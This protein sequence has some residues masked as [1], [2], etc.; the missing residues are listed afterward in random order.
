MITSAGELG[1]LCRRLA[2]APRIAFD[3][4]FVSEDTYRPEL[5]LI[6][7]AAG[8]GL[9]VI[10]ALAVGDVRPFWEVVAAEGHETIVHAGRQ[11]LLFCLESVGRPPAGLVDVQVAAALIGLE[12]PAGYG[13]LLSRLLGVAP[14]KGETRTDWR[15]RPLSERQ[16]H[17][18]LEDVRHLEPLRDHIF[19]RLDKL[20]RRGWFADEMAAWTV[21]IESS[22][23]RERWR[24]VSGSA[25]LSPRSQAIVRALWQWREQEA[26][27]RNCPTRQVLRDD[28]IV[29]LAKRRSADPK[30]ILAI[31]GMERGDLRRAAPEMSR[32][33]A[34]ALELPDRECP[35]SV[36][37]D[38]NP[39]LNLLG[40]FLSAALT[41][42]CRGAEVAHSLVGTAHDIRELAAFHLNKPRENPHEPPLLARG[43]RAQLVGNL[44]EELLSGRLAI[45]IQN[46][47][48][49]HPLVFEPS[50]GR[51]K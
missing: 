43:W 49:E 26:E 20:D 14:Q 22:R 33:I 25:S 11:E 37:T 42:V 46:P 4:E 27:R 16:I 50:A 24:R 6:Q 21:D 28:L 13:T 12:Y 1:E 7:V 32:A 44:F 17:Y 39:E 45:R 30:Q 9:W 48:S 2:D 15:R 40:Q 23:T 3:T 5:C 8:D 41:S 10:D 36:R 31:R 38:T 47:E 34:A 35:V 29:E 18:A 19:R 51:E